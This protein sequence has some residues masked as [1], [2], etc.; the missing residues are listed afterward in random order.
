MQVSLSS[1]PFGLPLTGG[2]AFEVE[3]RDLLLSRCRLV[4]AGGVVVGLILIV[5]ARLLFDRS[6]LQPRLLGRWESLADLSHLVSFGLAFGSLYVGRPGI[7]RLQRTA[8]GV[9]SFNL[10]LGVFNLGLLE[11]DYPPALL[12]ALLLF[13]PAAVIPWRLRYQVLLAVFAVLAPP[14]A[15]M[16]GYALH[17]NA[18]PYWAIRGGPGAFWDQLLASS[19]GLVLLATLSVLVTRTLYDLRKTAHEAERL[20]NYVVERKLGEG[21]MAVVYLARHARMVR[22]SA[23]KVLRLGDNADAGTLARFEREIRLASGL[24]HPNTIMIFDFGRASQ[25]T[26]YYAMEYLEGLDLEGLIDQFGPPPSRVVYLMRQVASSL[27]EAHAMDV[28]TG[29]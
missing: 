2:T 28:V 25:N 24:T 21:G 1:L 19:A 10:V 18:G 27:A 9:L 20:G 5:L 29:I 22:P 6:E 11:P 12:A 7:A 3:E 4:F 26:F 13:V 14:I 17:P 15:Q 8:F 16:L 23:V